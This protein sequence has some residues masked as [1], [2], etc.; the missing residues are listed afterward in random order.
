MKM[1][2]MEIDDLQLD[3]E[4]R[5][6]LEAYESGQLV[7]VVDKEVVIARLK[8]A[9]AATLRK[10]RRVNI[11][12]T[13]ADLAALQTIALEEGLPYQTLMASILHKYV[14][15]RLV[16]R[17]RTMPAAVEYAVHEEREPYNE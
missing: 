3:E 17:P 14:T 13:T 12:L 6:I 10:D 15:G 4:E 9:A 7:P 11:R 5:E 16:E 1:D 8:A 2:E